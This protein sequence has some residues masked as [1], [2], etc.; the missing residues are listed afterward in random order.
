VSLRVVLCRLL[1]LFV[2]KFFLVKLS[3][4]CFPIVYISERVFVSH[5]GTATRSNYTPIVARP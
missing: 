2:E 5:F 1:S 3:Q 4:I